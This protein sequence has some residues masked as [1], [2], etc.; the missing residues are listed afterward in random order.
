M[1]TQILFAS[2]DPLVCPYLNLAVYV[3]MFGTGGLGGEIFDCKSTRNFTNYLEK[4]FASPFFKAVREGMVGSHSLR[5]G[6]STYASRY[7]LLRDW[8]SLRGRWRGS[9]K[10]VNTY[11]DVDVWTTSTIT[12]DIDRRT[13]SSIRFVASFDDDG[14]S[15]HT[16]VAS[17]DNDGYSVRRL[18]R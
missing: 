12:D 17:I 10:Q 9:K 2:M 5:K 1:P 8:I 18:Y 4:L 7:G 14:Y 16:F 11:I 3:E 6:P 15:Q 13:R